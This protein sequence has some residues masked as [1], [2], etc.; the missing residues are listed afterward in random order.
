MRG[1]SVLGAARRRAEHTLDITEGEEVKRL[2]ASLA[3]DM[4]VNVAAITSID[5]CEKDPERAYAINAQAVSVMAA[6]CRQSGSRLVQISTDHFFTGDGDRLHD[7]AA[8]VTVVNEYARTKF[9]GEEFASAAPGAL[10]V[11]TNMTGRRGWPQPT[12]YEWAADSLRRHAPMA[13]FDD[14]FTS[15]IDAP[16]LARALFD[17]FDRKAEGLLNV[18]SREV[19]NKKSF[20]EAL[21]RA[22]GVDPDWM[23]VTSV[24]TLPVPR[25]ESAGLDVSRAQ[26]ILGYSLPDLRTVVSS[27]AALKEPA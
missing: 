10:I 3:P 12:F 20:V 27:L 18:A 7:E 23:T 8:P 1:H 13:L 21:A 19:A 17:L 14:Y 6:G 5:D 25:A 16:A 4:V 15:T 9:A 22:L 11:R 26:E 2:I 24:R